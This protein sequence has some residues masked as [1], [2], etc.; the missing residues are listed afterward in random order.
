[1]SVDWDANVIAPCTDV[2]GEP[3]TYMPANGEPFPI[4]G[5]FDEAY[6]EVVM[7][8][9]GPAIT[10]ESPVLGVRAAQFPSG[11][12]PHKGDQLMIPSVNTIYTVKDVRPDGHGHIKLMLNIKSAAS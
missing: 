7:L 1:M 8:D 9:N 4:E 6:H 10:T 2:F 5:V 11:Q 12:S 3:V